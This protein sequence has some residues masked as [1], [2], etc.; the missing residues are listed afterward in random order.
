[1]MNKDSSVNDVRLVGKR[2]SGFRFSHRSR[3]T[4]YYMA[5][6]VTERLSRTWDWIPVRVSE[7]Q[8]EMLSQNPNEYVLIRGYFQSFNCSEQG[9][10]RLLLSVFAKSLDILGETGASEN[11]IY[12]EG[13]VCR[14][15]VFRHT[16]AGMRVTD[17]LLAVNR[18]YRGTDYLPC[19]SWGK[20]ALLAAGFPVGKRIWLR[21]CT[22]SR[23]Y[24]K[25]IGGATVVR[26]AYEVSACE[27]GPMEAASS[28]TVHE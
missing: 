3:G 14:E 2:A 13:Y 27:V 8:C 17:I 22:Q 16:W 25:D 20:Y 1:M 5:D 23:D 21:G 11:S 28:Q 19:I 18:P 4:A 9:R 12:L 15:T 10:R 6:F 7:W 24:V 26:R